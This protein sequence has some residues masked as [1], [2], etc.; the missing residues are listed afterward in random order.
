[1]QLTAIKS[2]VAAGGL[3]QL[4]FPSSGMMSMPRV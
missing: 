3:R 2:R 4:I 1:M